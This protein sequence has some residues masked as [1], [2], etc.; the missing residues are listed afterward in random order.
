MTS[1]SI[2]HSGILGPINNNPTNLTQCG[3]A[4]KDV[5]FRFE[6]LWELGGLGPDGSSP[7]TTIDYQINI[8]SCLGLSAIDSYSLLA[9]S[10]A[11]AAD[12][13]VSIELAS[14][15]GHVCSS[16]KGLWVI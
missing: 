1:G 11:S 6:S 8:S 15:H 7:S 4:A 10:K 3:S 9:K 5:S 13:L 16:T 14:C 12:T 2:R